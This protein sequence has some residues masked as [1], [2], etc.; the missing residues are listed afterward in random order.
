MSFCRPMSIE[1]ITAMKPIQILFAGLFLLCASPATAAND[2]DAYTG[3]WWNEAKDGIFELRLTD[4]SIE[5]I[6]RWGK[7]PTKDVHNPDPALRDRWLKDIVFLWGFEYDARKNRWKGGQVYD[8]DSGKT[9]DAKM[10]LDK[11]GSVLKMRGFLGI[12][13]FGRTAKFDRVTADEIPPELSSE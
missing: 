3:L 6:T 13:M 10:E 2:A 7:V 11:G 12:S 4:G 8:P 5:G 1:R 9:Y